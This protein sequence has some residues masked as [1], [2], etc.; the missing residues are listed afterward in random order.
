MFDGV[1]R[2]VAATNAVR[3]AKKM[4]S[5]QDDVNQTVASSA[6]SMMPTVTT[7]VLQ[8]HVIFDVV[9]GRNA[10]SI[11]KVSDV[12]LIV[13]NPIDAMFAVVQI[14]AWFNVVSLIV[15]IVISTVRVVNAV[16]FST[17]KRVHS[18]RGFEI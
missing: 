1:T 4:L 14:V 9:K 10:T 6:V 17:I 7:A 5:A 12:I 18:Y 16:V 3:R 2:F 15:T 11:A 8:T 13:R